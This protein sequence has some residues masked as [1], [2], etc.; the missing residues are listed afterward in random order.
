MSE[1]LATG[2]LWISLVAASWLGM[3]AIHEAGHVLAATATGGTV[4]K[5]VLHPLTISR[6]DVSPNPQPLVV[7]WAG[8]VFGALAP[9]A[10][11]LVALRWAYS[12]LLRFFAGFCLIANGAYLAVG[13]FDRV[14]DAGDIQRGGS[15]MWTLWVFGAVCVPVGFWLWHGQGR[16]FG[17]GGGVDRRVA[18]G[19]FL[20]AVALAGVGMWFPG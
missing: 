15:P 17:F 12:Y 2:L 18:W 8:P 13:V 6:T 4:V 11:W 20:V 9:L 14:G 10:V 16:F 1:R 19:C 7:A 3:M 5:V